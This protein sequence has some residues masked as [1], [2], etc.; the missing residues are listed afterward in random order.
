MNDAVLDTHAADEVGKYHTY[1]RDFKNLNFTGRY[2]LKQNSQKHVEFRK[3]LHFYDSEF[4]S[5]QSVPSIINYEFATSGDDYYRA[6]I[7]KYHDG[8]IVGSG[9]GGIGFNNLPENIKSQINKATEHFSYTKGNTAF[10]IIPYASFSAKPILG[11]RMAEKSMSEWAYY[12]NDNYM[13]VLTG[14]S[15]SDLKSGSTTGNSLEMAAIGRGAS[16]RSLM[17]AAVNWTALIRQ[18]YN[19]ANDKQYYASLFAPELKVK[20]SDGEFNPIDTPF[21]QGA[22]VKF[23]NLDYKVTSAEWDHTLSTETDKVEQVKSPRFTELQA[24]AGAILDEAQ[25]PSNE[26]VTWE[27]N[28]S[29]G[30]NVETSF[31]Y[32]RSALDNMLK[33]IKA[34][35]PRLNPVALMDAAKGEAGTRIVRSE[36]KDLLPADSAWETGLLPHLMKLGLMGIM[37]SEASIDESTIADTM[38]QH[39]GTL[40]TG[41]LTW[42]SIFDD[43]NLPDTVKHY[44][45]IYKNDVKPVTDIIT[46]QLEKF[47]QDDATALT[48]SSALAVKMKSSLTTF[49]LADLHKTTQEKL[50]KYDIA[51]FGSFDTW[52]T[53]FKAAKDVAKASRTSAQQLIVDDYNK[54]ASLIATSLKKAKYFGNIELEKLSKEKLVKAMHAFDMLHGGATRPAIASIGNRKVPAPS[55]AKDFILTQ[56]VRDGGND[57]LSEIKIIK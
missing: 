21:T 23:G 5:S 17:N 56:G 13:K 39:A 19:G 49:N 6:L 54:I 47:I 34:L 1:T 27:I 31:Q 14:K 40:G 53:E 7:Q 35:D 26:K 55:I 57:F 3:N 48:L 22:E 50:A 8:E 38:L 43:A 20:S 28:L 12:G 24:I 9:P 45:D 4:V 32:K 29:N 16:F 33:V 52:F 30:L 11:T 37:E 51:G 15:L 46:G 2:Y 42:L 10:N 41:W 25:I 44:S 36:Y 18:F